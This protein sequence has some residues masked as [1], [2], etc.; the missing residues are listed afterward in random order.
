MGE[1][2]RK[3]Q[4][5][6]T[7][8]P[9]CN[10]R[11]VAKAQPVLDPSTVRKWETESLEATEDRSLLN[12]EKAPSDDE[13]FL[14]ALRDKKLSLDESLDYVVSRTRDLHLYAQGIRDNQADDRAEILYAGRL[15]ERISKLFFAVVA[16]AW[17]PDR[18]RGFPTKKGERNN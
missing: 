1:L 6:G 12:E 9:G 16:E 10:S 2:Q 17:D 15:A 18:T 5:S 14:D 11:H 4:R 13:D 7:V 3:V 8:L